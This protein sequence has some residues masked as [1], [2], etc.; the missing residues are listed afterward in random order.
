MNISQQIRHYRTLRHMSLQDL[1]DASGTSRG[2]LHLL[3]QGDSNPTLDKLELI[4]R[5]LGLTVSVLIGDATEQVYGE[6][7]MLYAY[8]A[9]DLVRMMTLALARCET[10]QS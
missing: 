1:A 2:Y 6:A 3:E 9:G 5:A 10:V 8:R 7:A 4:A